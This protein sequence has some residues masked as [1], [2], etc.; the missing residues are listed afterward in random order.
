MFGFNRAIQA[1]DDIVAKVKE[2]VAPRCE[3][4]AFWRGRA[5]KLGA[6]PG[7]KRCTLTGR[8]TSPMHS[9]GDYEA[10]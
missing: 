8:D 10:N 7:W 9:C 2:M 6:P 5:S 3:T 1:C 4:C